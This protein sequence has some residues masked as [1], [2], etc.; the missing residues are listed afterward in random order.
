[1]RERKAA[2]ELISRMAGRKRTTSGLQ[3]GRNQGGKNVKRVEVK[4]KK[5]K[6]K[7]VLLLEQNQF[8]ES[9]CQEGFIR[10]RKLDEKQAHM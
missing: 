10:K 9:T 5:K 8:V 1:M 7:R 3:S 4:K 6:K 2:T